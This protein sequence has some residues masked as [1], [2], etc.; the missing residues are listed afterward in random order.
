MAEA[1][2]LAVGVMALAG[3]FNNTVECFEFIQLGRNFGNNFQTSQLKLDNA[4]LR[5]SRWGYSLGLSDDIQNVQS[6][7][8]RFG[9]RQKIDQADALL[10]QILDLFVDAERVSQKYKSR[11]K[12]DDDSLATYNAQTNL[13]PANAGLHRKMRQLSMERQIGLVYGKRKNG[14]CMTRSASKG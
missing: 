1:A 3:L 14:R 2:S 9:S 8:Q 13:E 12:A 11:T 10:G 7:E 5:L 6:L 4:R